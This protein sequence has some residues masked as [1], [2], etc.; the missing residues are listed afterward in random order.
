MPFTSDADVVIRGQTAQQVYD[1]LETDEGLVALIR[2][3]PSTQTIELLA[4]DKVSVAN[5]L[6]YTEVTPAATTDD[7]V[8]DRVKFKLL[9]KVS[10]FGITFT[11]SLHGSQVTS[12][13]HLAQ[14]YES[15]LDSGAVKIH[16]LRKIAAREDGAVEIRETIRGTTSWILGAY[17]QSQCRKAHSLHVSRY[18]ELCA[19]A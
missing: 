3:S 13:R 16:K 6:T 11:I 19:N 12:R 5:N 4:H 9:E 10:Y 1:Y 18:T 15:E 17:V 14:I 2:L 7:E 8:C